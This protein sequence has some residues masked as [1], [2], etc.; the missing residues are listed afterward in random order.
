[1]EILI[2]LS[3]FLMG[4]FVGEAVTLFRVRQMVRRFTKLLGYD[5][6]EELRKAQEE[7][8]KVFLVRKLETEEV[9]NILYLYDKDTRDFIC[10]GSSMSELAELAKKNKNIVGAVVNHGEQVFMFADGKSEE[11]K[12]Q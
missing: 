3:I 12:F 10:Q 9:N 7:E 1:M 6:D 2:I 11:Y 5:L 4:Y 8:N